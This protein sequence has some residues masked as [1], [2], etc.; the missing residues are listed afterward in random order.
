MKK[1]KIILIIVIFALAVIVALQN[2]DEVTTKFLFASVTMPN[3]LLIIV[4]FAAG[5]FG[6]LIA[7]SLLRKKTP[8][9]KKE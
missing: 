4:T 1:F 7:G 6:G 8:K 2:R 3:M 5:F 9:P